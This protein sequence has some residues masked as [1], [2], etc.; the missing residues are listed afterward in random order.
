MRD[1][2]V[3]HQREILHEAFVAGWQA[4]LAVNITSPQVLAVIESCFELWL[5]EAVDETDVLGLVFRGRD[6][7]PVPTWRVVSPFRVRVPEQRSSGDGDSSVRAT[8]ATPAK[9]P[10]R[11]PA[12]AKTPSAEHDT[13]RLVHE[14]SDRG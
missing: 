3:D 12:G 10:A 2:R 7:L 9:K 4:A 11:P 14:S 8:R 13:D 5:E 1:G 6:D